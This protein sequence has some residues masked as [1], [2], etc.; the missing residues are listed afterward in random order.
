MADQ[1][2]PFTLVPPKLR[3]R[4]R[5][6]LAEE[7]RQL[8]G[9]VR[10]GY[11]REQSQAYRR[12]WLERACLALEGL[13]EGAY[14]ERE[15]GDVRNTT[16]FHAELNLRGNALAAARGEPEESLFKPGDGLKPMAG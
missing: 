16:D 12:Q 9:Q 14:G 15:P 1:P 10:N 2:D 8:A 3:L 11:V 13:A 7:A 4:R 6:D 5:R